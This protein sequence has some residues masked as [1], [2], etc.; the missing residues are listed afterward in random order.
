MG[1]EKFDQDFITKLFTFDDDV[2]ARCEDSEHDFRVIGPPE[3]VPPT[4]AEMQDPFFVSDH[5]ED[6]QRYCQAMES[7]YFHDPSEDY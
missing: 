4:I 7:G 2:G 5:P 1:D 3:R 6:A